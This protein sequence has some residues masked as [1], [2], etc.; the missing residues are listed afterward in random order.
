MVYGDLGRFKMEIAIYKRMIGFWLRIVKSK[1]S[2]LSNVFYRLLR[3]L[4][5]VNEY[6]SS[7][8]H[9]IKTILDSCGMSNIWEHPENFNPLWIINSVDMKLKDMERQVWHAEVERNILCSNY[10]AFKTEFGQEKY[11]TDLDIP[12]RIALSKYRYGSH[13]LP[14]C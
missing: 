12:D 5:E 11:I 1:E 4:Y 7:W 9:K 14:V 10:K 3:N 6:K 13:K 2:K 8:I